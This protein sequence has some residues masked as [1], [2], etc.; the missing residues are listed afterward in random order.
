MVNIGGFVGPLIAGYLRAISWDWVFVMSS[1]WILINFIPA[2][3]WYREPVLHTADQ[4]TIH[5]VL[6]EMLQVLGNGPVVVFLLLLTGFFTAYNQLFITLPVY[7]RDYVDTRD[8]VQMLA[9]W[10]PALLDYFAAV[11]IPQ[12]AAALPALATKFASL[13]AAEWPGLSAV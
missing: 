3:F 11:N 2:L 4:R 12:L 13:P 7:L 9:A 5:Q 10:S 8:L 6:Q 1:I